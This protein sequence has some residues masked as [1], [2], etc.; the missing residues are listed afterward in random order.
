MSEPVNHQDDSH[1]GSS[2]PSDNSRW[3]K[4]RNWL[5][6]IV[7][8][9]ALSTVVEHVSDNW[10]RELTE[11]NHSFVE[12]V[13]KVNPFRLAGLFYDYLLQGPP[14]EPPP[15]LYGFPIP[16]PSEPLQSVGF[17]TVLWRIIPGA[18]YTAKIIV[19]DGWVSALTALVALSLGFACVWWN[20]K[21]AE[22]L[23]GALLLLLAVPLVGLFLCGCSQRLCGSPVCYSA[24]C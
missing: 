20:L 3:L 19:S 4:I 7:V 12:G 17:G 23:Y 15:T 21:K 2:K 18:F 10:S 8:I 14:R 13:G 1:V 11:I 9:M 16:R 22:S 24:A 6:S 5:I